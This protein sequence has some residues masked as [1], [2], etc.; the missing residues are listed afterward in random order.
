MANFFFSFCLKV[1]VVGNNLDLTK[2]KLFYD[3]SDDYSAVAVVGLKKPNQ[4]EDES[5][6]LNNLKER[7]RIAAADGAH[8]LQ[9]LKVDEIEVDGFQDAEAAAEGV[10]L[11]LWCYDEHK[12]EMDK[13]KVPKVKLYTGGCNDKDDQWKIGVVKGEAQNI[14]RRFADAPANLMTPTIFSENAKKLFEGVKSVNVT[15]HD[16]KWIESQKMNTFLSVSKGSGEPPTFLEIK[17]T[18]KSAESSPIVLVGKGITFDTGGVNL[19]TASGMLDM[20]GDKGGAASVLAT[21][22]GIAKLN[23]PINVTTLIPLCENM[24]GSIANKPGD[25]I[26]AMNGKTVRID[27]TDAEGRLILA[28]A[29]HY[30]STLKPEFIVDVATLTGAMMIALGGEATGVFTNS[31]SLWKQLEEAGRYTGDRVWRLPLWK[32]YGKQLKSSH[33]VDLTNI[34]KSSAGGACSA[35][36]FLKEFVPPVDWM[37]LD[38]AGVMGPSLD[39]PYLRKGMTGRPTRTLIEFLKSRC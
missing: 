11:K 38:I 13:L 36:A 26:K 14:A 16:K 18:G 33:M 19:K 20:R 10:T 9:N 29:L 21:T 12:N 8:A 28:D 6:G 4:E 32:S 17:Y 3:L 22:Y 5:E 2:V 31:N 39:N 27:N 7:I 24:P 37:H 1:E 25:I 34:G 30:A 15:V 23:L 35:A